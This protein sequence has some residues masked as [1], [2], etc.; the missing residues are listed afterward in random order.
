[1]WIISFFQA[2][3][4]FMRT[5]CKCH[6]LSGSCTLRTCWRKLPIFH[7]VAT[8]L[9]E[10][11]DGAAKVIP[12]SHF[13]F[14]FNIGNIF[15]NFPFFLILK[16]VTTVKQSFRRGLALNHQVKRIWSTRK[17]HPITATPTESLDHSEHKE[18]FAM[19]RRQVWTAANCFA[20]VAATRLTR[21]KRAS[22]ATADSNGVAKS[23]VRR[24]LLRSTSTPAAESTRRSIKFRRYSEFLR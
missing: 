21:P 17:S 4:N 9:K 18:E 1:M 7:D 6:G 8:R 2:V 19:P 14:I 3:K 5:E 15:E 22:I 23:P 13:H 12:G 10:K 16:K 24:V 20:A 11:F